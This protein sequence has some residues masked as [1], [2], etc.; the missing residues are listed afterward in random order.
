[1]TD[2][3]WDVHDISGREGVKYDL[4]QAIDFDDDGDMDV[5]TCEEV[6][7]LGV[8]WYENPTKP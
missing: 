3:E 6:D 5:L 4:V 1:M 7:N 2:S 8:I